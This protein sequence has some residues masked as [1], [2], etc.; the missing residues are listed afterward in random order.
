VL[1][2]RIDRAGARAE[3]EAAGRE[4]A[5]RQRLRSAASHLAATRHGLA[6]AR[7]G[8][9][10]LLLPL[11]PGESAAELART[12]AKQLGTALHEPVTVGASA[13]L[14]EPL[15]HPERV[16]PAYDEARRCLDALRLLHRQG[17]GAAAEDLGFLGLLLA[18]TRDIEGFVDRTIGQVVAYDRRR[19]TDLV[20]T[21]DA[22]FACGMSPAR[23]KDEL[24]V[25][26]NT[27]AQRI[28]RIGRL[29]GPDWQSPARALEIQL[30]LRLHALAEAVVR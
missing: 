29:L 2:A 6:S 15:A 8:G 21:M 3:V 26:V 9:T 14:T 28:E 30:A 7:D 17:Q 22:Y 20:R 23:T 5:D 25:H 16:A 18:D 27:V 4:G 10:V 24:H 1:A 13:P 11:G 12:A 19:G